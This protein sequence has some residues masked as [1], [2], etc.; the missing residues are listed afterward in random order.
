MTLDL[1]LSPIYRINGQEIPSLPGLLVQLPPRS[2]ARGREQD[3]LFVYLLLTGTATFSTTEYLQVAQEAANVFFQ[4][5]RTLTGALRA[6]TEAVNTNLLNRNMNSSTRGQYAVGWLTMGSLRGEQLTLSMSGPMHAFWHGQSETRHI[7]EPNASGKGLGTSPNISIYYTQVTLGAGDRLI[8]LGRAPSAWESTLTNPAPA[9]LDAFRNRLKSLT[10]ADL[11]A[12]LVGASDGVGFMNLLKPEV[13][14]KPEPPIEQ[15]APQVTR[16]PEP[17]VSQPQTEMIEEPLEIEPETELEAHLV[18]PSA[19]AIPPQQEELKPVEPAQPAPIPSQRTGQR[20]FPASIPRAATPLVESQPA[21][22]VEQPIIE[23]PVETARPR[24]R[25]N[26]AE[27]RREPS[28]MTR[29]TAKVLANTIQTT[30]RTSSSMSEKLLGFLPR[31]L[32]GADVE[33]SGGNVPSTMTMIF[34]AVLIPLMV[35]TVASVVYLRYGRSQQYE[36]YLAQANELK[37]QAQS[38]TDPVEQRIAW[39]NVLNSVGIAETHRETS[40]TINLRNEAEGEIDK[41][42]G[43]NRLQFNAAFSSNLGVDISRLAA[44]ETDLYLLN[45]VNG[46]ILRAAPAR[47]GR[48]FELDTQFNCRPG[49]HKGMTIGPLVDILTLP[50]LNQIGATVLG[51]DASGNLLYC[52]PGMDEE[53]MPLPTPET[54]WGRV[55]GFVMDAG[56]LYVL[57]APSRA[58]WV[59]PGADSTFIK[60]PLFFFGGQT[61]EKQ[62]VIDMVVKG[63]ILYMLHADGHLSMCS[64]SLLTTVSTRCQDPAPYINPIPAY[65]DIDV[66]SGAHF[67]Q[68]LFTALP[69]QSLLLLDSDSASRGLFRFTP[70]SIELQNQFRPTQG[71]SNPIPSGLPIGAVTVGSN[72]VLY[73]AVGGQV[74]FATDMP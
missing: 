53:P 19:Y 13:Q 40:D 44:G 52:G 21:P 46:E 9:P 30:R 5:P 35:V 43:I 25:Q 8:F 23:K 2:P 66:F 62:D 11:N 3:R 47:T 74:Y 65:R 63:E 60:Q 28:V 20:E 68:I 31:L 14:A 33:T 49:E 48:G 72:H 26:P 27:T 17:A 10:S 38:L 45:A 7:H 32:P 67:T 64:S 29:Q 24:K 34:L 36:S 6:A 16:A 73:L 69:D 57:D 56:D 37:A 61:P 55:T 54:G 59:Y 15:P 51:V 70:R 18:Q 50:V 22:V 4:T 42:L 41:L 58:V 12:V 71:S 39:E 1:T